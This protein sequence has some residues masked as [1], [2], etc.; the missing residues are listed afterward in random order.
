MAGVG[1]ATVYR[2][3]PGRQQ[4]LLA[5]LE[6]AV[7]RLEEAAQALPSDDPGTFG[8]LLRAAVCEQAQCQGLTSV[9]RQRES[10][11]VQVDRLTRRVQSLFEEPLAAAKAAGVV[12]SARLGSRLGSAGEADKFRS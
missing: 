10:G 2:H 8:T 4:L 9:L 1:L 7:G 5:L 3:F 6:Q 12:R 11:R